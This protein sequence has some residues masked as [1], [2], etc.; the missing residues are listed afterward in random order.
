MGDVK[1][2]Q[3]HFA[4]PGLLALLG[5]AFYP[6][7]AYRPEASRYASST[8]GHPHAVALRFVH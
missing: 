5:S 2:R 8:H 4:K 6:V 7:L 3:G 1:Q